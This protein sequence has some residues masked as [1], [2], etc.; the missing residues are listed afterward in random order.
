MILEITETAF[1]QTTDRDTVYRYECYIDDVFIAFTTWREKR[2]PY[3]VYQHFIK[4]VLR[5]WKT[6]YKNKY[7]MKKITKHDMERFNPNPRTIVKEDIQDI[8]LTLKKANE[9]I[10]LQKIDEDFT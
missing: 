2:E 7:N 6:E 10:R 5:E 9:F 1:K 3:K 4:C 8:E